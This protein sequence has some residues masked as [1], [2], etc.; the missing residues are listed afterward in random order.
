MY[1]LSAD[2][3]DGLRA[4]PEVFAGLLSN[5]SPEQA[6]SARGGDEDWSIVEVMCHLRDAEERALERTEAMRDT[7]D[8]FLPGYDQAQWAR[9]RD[10]ASADLRDALAAFGRFRSRHVA[11]LAALS[12]D[13][14]QRTGRHEEQG[15]ITIEAQALHMA[16]H[17]AIHA[18]QIARQ[19]HTEP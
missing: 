2:T 16:A 12:P 7:D 18:A 15:Q 14:W 10:Y 5:C 19:L 6:R 4:G 9:E 11:A 8:P 3:L 13:A 17:D 1:D